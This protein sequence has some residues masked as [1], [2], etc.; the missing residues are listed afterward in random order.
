[1]GDLLAARV[2]PVKQ[3]G[4]VPSPPSPYPPEVIA[5][6]DELRTESRQRVQ[7]QRNR[8]ASTHIPAQFVELAPRYATPLPW[9]PRV[10][11]CTCSRTPT[12]A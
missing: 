2:R 4:D 1:M 11:G 6:L 8:P 9:M 10:R 12:R 5:T 3:L 7:A